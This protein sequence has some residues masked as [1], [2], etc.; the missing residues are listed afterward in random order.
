MTD[1][2]AFGILYRCAGEKAEPTV[3]ILTVCDGCGQIRGLEH[4]G[5]VRS[6][7]IIECQCGGYAAVWVSE[8]TPDG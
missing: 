2:E 1:D 5:P 6:G 7:A 3:S 8:R 4:H